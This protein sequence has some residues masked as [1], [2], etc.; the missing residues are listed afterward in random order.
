[1]AVRT[2]QEAVSRSDVEK[3]DFFGSTTCVLA[4]EVQIQ[5]VL[6]LV[7]LYV[8]PWNRSS[9]DQG[10]RQRVVLSQSLDRSLPKEV[11]AGVAD[12]GD[13]DPILAE[14][15]EDHGRRHVGM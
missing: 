9:F 15:G 13:I 12:A 5:N 4:A 8:F 14:E 6:E 11:G 2:E 3:S 1:E 7:M 10:V